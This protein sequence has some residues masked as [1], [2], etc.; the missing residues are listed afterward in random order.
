MMASPFVQPVQCQMLLNISTTSLV[1]ELRLVLSDSVTAYC[2]EMELGEVHFTLQSFGKTISIDGT[3]ATSATGCT[4]WLLPKRGL[5]LAFS[6]DPTLSIRQAAAEFLAQ[7]TGSSQGI[8]WAALAIVYARWK[9][10]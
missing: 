5:S 1:S 7:S 10:L 2:T 6:A 4:Q 9:S 3:L 8:C